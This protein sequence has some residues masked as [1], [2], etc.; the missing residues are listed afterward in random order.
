MHCK[1]SDNKKDKIK[2]IEWGDL[3]LSKN[4]I[5]TILQ[6]VFTIRQ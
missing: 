3:L 5:Q 6:T 1:A 2:G 4:L